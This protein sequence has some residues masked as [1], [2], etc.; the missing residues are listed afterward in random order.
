MKPGLFETNFRGRMRKE[1]MPALTVFN[2]SSVKS[3]GCLNTMA[4]SS[5]ETRILYVVPWQGGV[6]LSAKQSNYV[7]FCRQK[8][9]PG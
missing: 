3:I 9:K 4:R 5:P 8:E 2:Q 7:F 6:K 1:K